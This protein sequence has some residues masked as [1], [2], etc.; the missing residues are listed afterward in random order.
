MKLSEKQRTFLGEKVMDT[1]NISVGALFFG[2]LISGNETSV[3]RLIVGLSCWVILLAVGLI[4]VK[5]LN[6]GNKY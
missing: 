2:Q 4:L 5:G 1:A 6:G 3:L